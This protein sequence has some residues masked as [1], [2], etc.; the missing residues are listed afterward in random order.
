MKIEIG[1]GGEGSD[2]LARLGEKKASILDRLGDKNEKTVR[3]AP[4]G[5]WTRGGFGRDESNGRT[6][7]KG[8][9]GRGKSNFREKLDDQLNAYNDGDVDMELTS[10]NRRVVSYEEV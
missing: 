2:I 9:R 6:F 1:A 4:E 8:G 7:N 3:G 10:R 5:M